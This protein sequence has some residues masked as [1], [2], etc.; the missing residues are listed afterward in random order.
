MKKVI[1]SINQIAKKDYIKLGCYSILH[2]ETNLRVIGLNP[3]LVDASNTYIWKNATNKRGIVN[4][5]IMH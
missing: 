4:L 2:P 5:K 1:L 3:L